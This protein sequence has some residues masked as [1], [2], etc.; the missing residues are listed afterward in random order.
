MPA[1]TTPHVG[2]AVAAPSAD[3]NLEALDLPGANGSLKVHGV[4][5]DLKR[6]NDVPPHDH[7]NHN[8][9]PL[10]CHW[11][12]SI[13]NYDSKIIIH[14]SIESL[15]LT[16]GTIIGICFRWRHEDDRR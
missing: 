12:S 3:M 14:T 5:L 15:V 1:T 7:I 10:Q 4:V 9:L 13:Y 8:A 16:A 2:R 11:Q 6:V